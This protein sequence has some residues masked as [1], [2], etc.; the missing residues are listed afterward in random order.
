MEK[1]INHISATL[2]SER[3]YGALFKAAAVFVGV[4]L[5]ALSQTGTFLYEKDIA[6]YK[7]KF[8]LEIAVQQPIEKIDC[9]KPGS[10]QLDCLIVKHELHTLDASLKLLDIVVQT[11]FWFGIICAT[12]SA[13]GFVCSPFTASKVDANAQQ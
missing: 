13:I 6:A 5:I 10:L 2:C 3:G 1:L 12:L 8:T 9:T 4:A 11:S 7:A